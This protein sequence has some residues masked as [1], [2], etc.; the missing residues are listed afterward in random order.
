M[1]PVHSSDFE[2]P[3]KHSI[4]KTF[5]SRDGE[6]DE[7]LCDDVRSMVMLLLLMLNEFFVKSLILLYVEKV[8]G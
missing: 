5:V 4:D 6:S 2:L 7:L 8:R 1:S 3:L